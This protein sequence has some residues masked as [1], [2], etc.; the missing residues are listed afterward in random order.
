[1]TQEDEGRQDARGFVEHLPAA[2]EGDD[3]AVTPTGADRD[4]D[5]HHHV[6]SPGA[7]CPI[8]AI[9]EDPPGVE[10]HGQ[11]QQQG[12]NVVAQAERR[13]GAKP[14][15]VPADGRIEE[16]R[17]RQA[18]GDEEPASHVGDH[19]V[20]RHP[21]VASAVSHGL[22]RG[23]PGGRDVSG[24]GFGRLW[25]SVARMHI[26]ALM[27]GMLRHVRRLVLRVHRVHRVR[28]VRTVGLSH[29]VAY[30]VGDGL[31]RTVVP[32]IADPLG[33]FRDRRH[34]GV[35]RDC[36]GLGDGVHVHADDSRL[37]RQD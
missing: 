4:G 37:A 14:E 29:R 31:A 36:R 6:Q 20:H 3:N 9:E 8:C 16:D 21:R 25:W 15:H 24:M 2:G 19:R 28:I 22:L 17:D 23:L 18:G 13:R 35:V 11:A 32:T 12:D 10:D 33:E 1:M 30:V 26:V 5:E 27:I 7:Q 34:R